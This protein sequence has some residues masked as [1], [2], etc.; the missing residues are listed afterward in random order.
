MSCGVLEVASALGKRWWKKSKQTEV[1]ITANGLTKIKGRLQWFHDQII[2]ISTFQY[3]DISKTPSTSF[4][5][6]THK[7]YRVQAGMQYEMP[8]PNTF[9]SKAKVEF[10][11]MLRKHFSEEADVKS[12]SVISVCVLTW[13]RSR[14]LTCRVIDRQWNWGQSHAISASTSTSKGLVKGWVITCKPAP[15]WSGV[16]N[17]EQWNRKASFHFAA[18]LLWF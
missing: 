1:S 2:P 14:Q 12:Y 6:N 11:M 4:L 3:I 16:S 7:Y 15:C 17:T 10:M 9:S 13:H 18:T 8:C 5:S